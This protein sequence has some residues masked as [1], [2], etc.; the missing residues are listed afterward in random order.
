MYQTRALKCFEPTSSPL[1]LRQRAKLHVTEA[2][3]RRWPGSPT[4]IQ[5]P[6]SV[7][8]FGTSNAG[9]TAGEAGEGAFPMAARLT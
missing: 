8:R 1:T 9:S 7:T 6:A 5:C 4:S 3:G 2:M